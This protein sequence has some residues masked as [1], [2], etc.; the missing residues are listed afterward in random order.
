VK[1]TYATPHLVVHGTVEDLTLRNKRR[2]RRKHRP[3]GGGTG[4]GTTGGGFVDPIS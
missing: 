3:R 1:K 2:R 4:G